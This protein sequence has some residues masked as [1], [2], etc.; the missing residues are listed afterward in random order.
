MTGP[1]SIPRRGFRLERAV[2]V[3]YDTRFGDHRVGLLPRIE[4]ACASLRRCCVVHR[5]GE[6]RTLARARSSFP[7]HPPEK[8]TVATCGTTVVVRDATVTLWA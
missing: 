6:E 3:P 2:D 7:R 4:D 1:A 8:T 5:P